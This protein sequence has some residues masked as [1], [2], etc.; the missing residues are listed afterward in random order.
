MKKNATLALSEKSVIVAT[1]ASKNCTI[2]RAKI[3]LDFLES[4]QPIELRNLQFAAFDHHACQGLSAGV[5]Q[6]QTT[7]RA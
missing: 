4:Q 3:N 7:A 2:R 5:T 1:T 6:Q